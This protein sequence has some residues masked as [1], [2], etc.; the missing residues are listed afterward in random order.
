MEVFGFS[1]KAWLTYSKHA[2][3][4]TLP[5]PIGHPPRINQENAAMVAQ[6]LRDNAEN[7]MATLATS[8]ESGGDVTL[9]EMLQ[10]AADK[11]NPKKM[12]KPLGKKTVQ[13]F[14]K[15]FNIARGTAA[16]RT[17]ARHISGNDLRNAMSTLTAWYSLLMY[18][19]VCPPQRTR[20]VRA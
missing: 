8:H 6:T 3:N 13:K 16:A 9:R 17:V 7:D 10:E 11:S 19:D 14:K 18:L 1:K 5:L 12:G 4:G 20:I 2:K 15:Q